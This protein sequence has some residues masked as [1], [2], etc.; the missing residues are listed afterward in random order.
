MYNIKKSLGAK[1]YYD[2]KNTEKNIKEK[3]V[4]HKKEC[5][6]LVFTEGV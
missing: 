4:F 5:E 2:K 6:I 1:S 3:R